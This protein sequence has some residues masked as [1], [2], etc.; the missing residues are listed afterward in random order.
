MTTLY[1]VLLLA[2]FLCFVAAA[3]GLVTVEKLVPVGLACW[4][5]VAL[6]QVGRALS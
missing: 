3:L 6:I 1:F 5:L 2:A 4:V